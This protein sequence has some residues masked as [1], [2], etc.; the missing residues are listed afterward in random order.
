MDLIDEQIDA[1]GRAFLGMTVGC[2]RCHDHKFDPI[3]T[4]DYYALAGIFDSTEMLV[5]RQRQGE[6]QE[7]GNGGAA[8]TPSPTAARPWASAKAEPTD[9]AICIRGDSTKRG[10]VV[11]RGFLTAAVDAGHQ[12]RRTSRRAA[13]WNWRPG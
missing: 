12:A 4:K 8:C 13:G 6:Q 5:R 7:S 2:A 1:I 9:T 11:P 3:P 10:D